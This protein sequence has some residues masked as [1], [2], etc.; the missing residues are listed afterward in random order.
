MSHRQ[1]SHIDVPFSLECSGRWHTL[2]QLAPSSQAVKGTAA[3]EAP[4]RGTIYKSVATPDTAATSPKP[5][6]SSLSPSTSRKYHFDACVVDEFLYSVIVDDFALKDASMLK[7]WKQTLD[8]AHPTAQDQANSRTEGAVTSGAPDREPV[9]SA[10]RVTPPTQRQKSA[11]NKTPTGEASGRGVRSMT[12]HET[13]EDADRRAPK[14]QRTENFSS[15]NELVVLYEPA[16]PPE[17]TKLY[18]R[19]S[20]TYTD[21]ALVRSYRNARRVLMELGPCASDLVCHSF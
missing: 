21:V 14:K 9:D 10:V 3:T 12:H 6:Q 2:C 7:L 13:E 20:Q 15:A 17:D 11:G 16:P 4:G 18:G 8:K 19:L 5:Q 1:C